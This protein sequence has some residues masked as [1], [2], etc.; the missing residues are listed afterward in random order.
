MMMPGIF[1]LGMILLLL[2]PS[3]ASSAAYDALRIWG[4]DVVPSLFPY[5]VLCQALSSALSGRRLVL[6]HAAVALGLLGGSP[7]GSAALASA[8]EGAPMKRRRLFSLCALTGTLSPMFFLGPL[9]A[10]TSPSIGR[11]LLLTHIGGALLASALLYAAPGSAV[12]TPRSAAPLQPQERN[13]LMRS[14][15]TVLSVGGCIVFFSAVSGCIR[16]LFPFLS[17]SVLALLHAFSEIS[18]GMRA[19]AQ[20]NLSADLRLVLMSAAAGLTGVS[21]LIQN[22]LFLGPLGISFSTLLLIGALRA[23]CSAMIALFLNSALP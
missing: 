4:L 16:P 6:R 18:G 15:H 20:L 7:S 22:L 21:V 12:S 13:P 19:M 9:S 10:W 23:A 17:E 11:K 3:D 5:M 8:A 14:I 2:F 1:V